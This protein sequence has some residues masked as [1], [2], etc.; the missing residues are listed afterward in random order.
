MARFWT[1][2]TATTPAARHVYE[3]V[4]TDTPVHLYF[5][6]EYRRGVVELP[7]GTS[8]CLNAGV[9]G[10]DLVAVLLAGVT[11]A[12]VDVYG[13]AIDRRDVVQLESSTPTKFS[14]HL[15]LRCPDG[16]MWR[17]A[18]AAG[19]FVR[20]VVAT[21]VASDSTALAVAAAP[22]SAAPAPA[23]D[24]A[25][26]P[27]PAPAATQCI[28]DL[29]V[30]TRNRA[31][32]M[33]LS[34]KWGKSTPLLPAA[35]SGFDLEAPRVP[36]TGGTGAA[37]GGATRDAAAG[38]PEYWRGATGAAPESVLVGPSGWE[39]RVWLAS[40]ITDTLPPLWLTQVLASDSGKLTAA[41]AAA[42]DAWRRVMQVDDPSPHALDAA[43]A[44]FDDMLEAHYSR[45]A[46]DLAAYQPP[47]HPVHGFRLLYAPDALDAPDAPGAPDAGA[48]GTIPSSS[49]SSTYSGCGGK[50][51][52]GN[53]AE[54]EYVRA[55]AGET[56]PYPALTAYVVSN[57]AAPPSRPGAAVWVRG[58]G[59]MRWRAGGGWA[60][61]DLEVGGARWCGRVGREHASNH[62][63]WHVDLCGGTAWQ[64]CHDP[65]CRAAGYVSPIARLPPDLLAALPAAPPPRRPAAALPLAP[66]K[67]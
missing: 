41:A 16:A 61:L 13:I 56:P 36:G 66:D 12:M 23:L 55:P 27:A 25:P 30:Y 28:V 8:T 29:G 47:S 15:L 11:R 19:A 59:G 52:S 24:P 64:T 42:N 6:L 34:T 10:D 45:S 57:L 14:R 21:L 62:V 3:L 22:S 46:A 5:D 1:Q 37:A 63:T 20:H 4:R 67:L 48:G 31:M 7:D 40:L 58:W 39:Q 43:A 33:Y 54:V 9:V 26:A 17:D 60:R 53:S 44:V 50:G 35:C 2:Y 32:R 38:T 49:A 65:D 18:A 51:G